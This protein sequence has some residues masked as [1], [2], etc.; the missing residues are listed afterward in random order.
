MTSRTVA[1]AILI[2][3]A[4]LVAAGCASKKADP[5]LKKEKEDLSEY[6]EAAADALRAMKATLVSFDKACGEHPCSPETLKTFNQDVQ[7]LEIDSFKL[8]A[9]AQAMKV[10]GDAYFQQ[11]HEHLA[12]I[13]DAEARQLATERHDALQE[14]FNKIRDVSKDTREAFGTY[15]SGVHRVR[16]AL[17]TNPAAASGEKLQATIG[18]T[19]ESGQKVVEGLTAI[20]EELKK[21]LAILKPIKA[22]K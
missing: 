18:K 6:R 11:W 9:R 2:A 4:L 7:Q 13:E 3:A 5:V 22:T 16:N 21:D 1:P 20:M 10:M 19:R 8:R 12:A 14:S 17:E 15:I